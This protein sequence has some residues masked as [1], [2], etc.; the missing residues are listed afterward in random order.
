[1]MARQWLCGLSARPG[2]TLYD[3]RTES[4]ARPP[5][6]PEC[7]QFRIHLTWPWTELETLWWLTSNTSYRRDCWGCSD[8]VGG[9][10]GSVWSLEATP[11]PPGETVLPRGRFWAPPGGPATPCCPGGWVGTKP[12]FSP[13][14]RWA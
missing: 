2:L 11:G 10:G 14:S 5:C 7:Q 9:S 13:V 6:C 8:R 3:L 4:G 12:P 1:M